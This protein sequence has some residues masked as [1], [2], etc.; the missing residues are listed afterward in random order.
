MS[1]GADTRSEEI[2]GSHWRL[3]WAL[4]IKRLTRFAVCFWVH[5][6]KLRP[7]FADASPF[8]DGH[9]PSQIFQVECVAGS[10]RLR[11]IFCPLHGAV[12]PLVPSC[13]IADKVPDVVGVRDWGLGQREE[14]AVKLLH[15]PGKTC[16]HF[17]FFLHFFF[18]QVQPSCWSGSSV[19]GSSTYLDGGYESTG[20]VGAEQR[21]HVQL[22]HVLLL[23]QGAGD[24]LLAQELQ[25]GHPVLHAH[26]V[27]RRAARQ[28]QAGVSVA[29]ADGG[30]GPLKQ[31]SGTVVSSVVPLFS[32]TGAGH[33]THHFCRFHLF[34]VVVTTKLILLGINTLSICCADCIFKYQSLVEADFFGDT[35]FILFAKL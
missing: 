34:S 35:Y 10:P 30:D 8:E 24:A 15:P 13:G 23:S 12:E 3:L 28:E 22:A 21:G 1:L 17:F 4:L 2:M 9:Q 14:R 19:E 32:V 20:D 31:Q 25:A 27:Q 5:D 33:V 16:Q 6:D 11:T 7:E 29:P 26:H 18:P